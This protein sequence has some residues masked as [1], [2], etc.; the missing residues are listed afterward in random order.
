MIKLKF[1]MTMFLMLVI[2][3]GYLTNLLLGG[4]YGSIFKQYPPSVYIALNLALT[5]IIPYI[6]ASIF[7]TK[8]DLYN[9]LPKTIPGLNLLVTGGII[10][11]LPQVLRIF[12]SMVEGGG[13]SF[14]LMSLAAP[15][16]LVAKIIVYIGLIKL[17]M[18]VKPHESY[19]YQ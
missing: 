1:G 5:L 19:V 18:S 14:V 3:T 12:T 4:M 11:L 7:I 9:R 17:L 8:T 16:V 6:L 15:L 13:V 2:P 10:I